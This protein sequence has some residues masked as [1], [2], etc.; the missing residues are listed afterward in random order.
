MMNQKFYDLPEEKQ[1]S[2]INAGY[3]VFSMNTYRKS[4][5]NEIA[6]A[7]GI[8]KSLLFHYFENK[9]DLYMF[10]WETCG[11]LSIRTLGEYGCYEQKDLFEMLYLGMRAKIRIMRDYPYMASFSI[12]AYYEPDPQIGPAIRQS[13]KSLK[14]RYANNALAALDPAQFIEGID[15]SMMLREMYLAS[16]GYLWEVLQRGELLLKG[17]LSDR[18]IE[19][20]EHDFS[21]MIAFWKQIYLRKGD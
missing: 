19:T 1:R 7:A 17:A 12:R 10:L 4:P 11:E 9:K 20:I 21:K 18:E 13:Y 14:N 6:A 5:M 16:E 3:R 2:V 15:L 8:S